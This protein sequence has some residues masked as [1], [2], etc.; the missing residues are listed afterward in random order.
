LFGY[1]KGDSRNYLNYYLFSYNLGPNWYENF[2][3]HN[4][5]LDVMFNLGIIA[6]VIFL[7]YLLYSIQ[8]AFKSKNKNYLFFILLIS[9]VFLFDAPLT[10][11]NGVVY[12]YLF[13]AI[14]IFKELTIENSNIRN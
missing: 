12:F 8:L 1:G 13:N 2:N 9:F 4:Q 10:I 11:N 7:M 5:Y 3:L 6:L 14:F